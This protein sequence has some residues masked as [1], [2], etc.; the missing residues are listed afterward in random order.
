MTR[1]GQ[2]W[3]RDVMFWLAAR[4]AAEAEHHEA[5]ARRAEQQ[6]L[7]LDS[8]T[9]SRG[10]R[11]NQLLAEARSHWRKAL[12]LRTHAILQQADGSPYQR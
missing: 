12:D 3:G 9:D 5:E 1:N 4:Y 6:A 2:S 10:E 8:R 11:R 7:V